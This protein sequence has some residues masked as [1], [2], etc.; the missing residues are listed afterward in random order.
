LA[1]YGTVTVYLAPALFVLIVFALAVRLRHHIEP[2]CPACSQRNWQ[3]ATASMA[4]TSCGWSA[5]GSQALADTGHR[6][7]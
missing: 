4:C 7:I 5:A 6:R 2:A 3:S 1:V